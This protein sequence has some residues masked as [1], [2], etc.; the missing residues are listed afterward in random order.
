MF[1]SLKDI[2]VLMGIFGIPSIFSICVYCFAMVRKFS[3]R[4]TILM[5]A[6]QAQMRSQL[7][8]DYHVYVNQGYI[9]EDD[10]EDWDN[11]YQS[12]HELGQNGILD[13]RREQLLTLP[14]SKTGGE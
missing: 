14:N 12:Y 11:R 1:S 9:S 10:L 5:K 6:Q 8:N 7:L 3:K 13:T 4:V 2:V